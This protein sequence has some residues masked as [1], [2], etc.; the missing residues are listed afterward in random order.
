[1][2]VGLFARAIS[3]NIATLTY[4]RQVASLEHRCLVR[5]PHRPPCRKRYG[6]SAIRGNPGI[7]RPNMIPQIARGFRMF[8]ETF[9]LFQLARLTATFAGFLG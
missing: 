5:G 9:R 4:P 8:R 1:M 7:S 6:V 2:V 3:E